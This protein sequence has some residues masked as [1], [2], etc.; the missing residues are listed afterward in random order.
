MWAPSQEG[1]VLLFVKDVYLGFLVN[2]Q[3]VAPVKTKLKPIFEMPNPTNVTELKSFLGMVGYY[4][5]HLPQLA[6]CLEPL[7]SLLRKDIPWR[8]G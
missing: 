6:G 8:W 3:G 2:E 7:H 1:K 5:W 4:P